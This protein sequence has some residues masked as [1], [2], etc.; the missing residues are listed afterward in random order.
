MGSVAAGASR[1]GVDTVRLGT[2][3]MYTN[4]Q[5]LESTALQDQNASSTFYLLPNLR[6]AFLNEKAGVQLRTGM[7]CAVAVVF[8]RLSSRIQ[9]H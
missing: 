3:A 1:S 2:V 8:K 7:L 9:P 5:Q 4:W 6:T